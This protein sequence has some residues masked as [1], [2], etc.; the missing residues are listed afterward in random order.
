MKILI[1]YDEWLRK[2]VGKDYSEISAKAKYLKSE[3]V[4]Y[5]YH[6]FPCSG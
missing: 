4:L 5:P 1:L 3:D 6:F 2:G